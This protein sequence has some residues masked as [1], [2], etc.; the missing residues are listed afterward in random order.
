MKRIIILL[1]IVTMIATSLLSSISGA[2]LFRNEPKKIDEFFCVLIGGVGLGAIVNN[3]TQSTPATV[4]AAFIGGAIGNDYCKNYVNN[5]E[6][7]TLSQVLREEIGQRPGA[8]SV[9]VQTEKVHAALTI[10]EDGE[11]SESWGTSQCI[12]FEASVYKKAYAPNI[13]MGQDPFMGRTNHYWACQNQSGDYEITRSNSGIRQLRV[14]T[15]TVPMGGIM[16]SSTSGITRA[17]VNT[18]TR[19]DFDKMSV[20]PVAKDINTGAVGPLK[21]INRLWEPGFFAGRATVQGIKGVKVSNGGNKEGDGYG[22]LANDSQVGVECNVIMP[23]MTTPF[24]RSFDVRNVAFEG[25]KI[26]G[27]ASYIFQDQSMMVMDDMNGP[28][29]IPMNLLAK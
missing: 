2:Q 16:S 19:I 5:A 4:M 3:I 8:S 20:A 7:R 12:Y 9:R 21:M 26:S 23:G 1:V 14:N 27:R 10:F 28:Q 29:I 17:E 22:Y 18:W 6:Y 11:R 25:M 13:T 15:G 24:C